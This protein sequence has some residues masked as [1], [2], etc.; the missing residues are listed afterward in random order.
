MRVVAATAPWH[1][2]RQQSNFLTRL[3]DRAV[4]QPDVGLPLVRP[5]SA[6]YE[7]ASFAAEPPAQ[8]L[9]VPADQ[10]M[11]EPRR[12]NMAAP[13]PHPSQPAAERVQ[14][15]TARAA[16]QRQ[17]RAEDAPHTPEPDVASEHAARGAAAIPSHARNELARSSVEARPV[18]RPS[19]RPAREPASERISLQTV[20]N[21]ILG[22]E[23]VPAE[24]REPA[25]APAQASP[26]PFEQRSDSFVQAPPPPL[27][28]IGRIDIS[29]AP[30]RPSPPRESGPPRSQGFANYSRIRRGQDR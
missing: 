8:A 21:R 9:E 6:I 17:A 11:G 15:R 10:E 16:Q 5:L 1:M 24:P 27:V 14:P 19:E 22:D 30:P 20:I 25:P 29:V 26:A 23:G 28:S 7:S 18:D 12:R 3:V 13:R 4:R 2:G